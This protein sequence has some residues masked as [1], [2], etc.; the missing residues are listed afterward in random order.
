MKTRYEKIIEY[1]K[2]NGMVYF[3][4]SYK[5]TKI[6]RKHINTISTKNGEDIYINGVDYSYCKITAFKKAA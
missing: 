4:N 3:Q 2:N 5:I 1:L 6:T